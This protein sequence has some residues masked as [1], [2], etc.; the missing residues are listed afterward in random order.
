MDLRSL[1]RAALLQVGNSRR[2]MLPMLMVLW[3][4]IMA[5]SNQKMVQSSK[6]GPRRHGSAGVERA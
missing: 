3:L 5:M 2:R 1:G 6:R 4:D